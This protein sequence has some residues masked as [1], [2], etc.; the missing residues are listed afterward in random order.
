MV[1]FEIKQNS[2]TKQFYWHLKADNGEIIANGETYVSKQACLNC[3]NT[4]RRVASSAPLVDY[5]DSSVS[6]RI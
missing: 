1:Q 5:T 6:V 3:I 4:L 2:T